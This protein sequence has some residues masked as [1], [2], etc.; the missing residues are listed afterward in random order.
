MKTPFEILIDNI[1]FEELLPETT[2][3]PIT[4]KYVLSMVNDFEDNHWRYKKFHQFIWNNISKDAL[5]KE[6]RDSL[7]DSPDSILE[8]AASRLRIIQY[9]NGDDETT[10]GEIAEILLYGVMHSYYKALPVVP[11]IFY[12][13]NKNDYAKGA[14][15]VH[16]VVEDNDN[17]SLWLGE[18]KF[19]KNIENSNL[20]KIVSSVHDTL[21]TNKIKKEN[22]IITGLS[23]F[24]KYDISESIKC[25]I[26]ELLNED[27][28]IDQIKPILHI[29]IILL[30][31]CEITASSNEMSENYKKQIIAKH[32]ERANSYFTK[33]I[34]KCN[35]VANYSKIN[36]HIILFPV[37]CKETVVDKFIKRAKELRDED[38]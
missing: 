13:Q 18:A 24:D 26:K 1:S 35:K 23:E 17:F 33:Q 5:T 30:H 2:L 21:S 27:T 9:K 7:I 12:K 37:P 29:P 15:S 3:S 14:D 11:K 34:R 31:E 36:F 6:E 8:K 16:I 22:S 4:N 25:K 19:Y 20:D 32:K 38:E 10:G 28:S